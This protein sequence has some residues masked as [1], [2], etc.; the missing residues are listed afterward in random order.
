VK[1]SRWESIAW[2]EE[3]NWCSSST[4][5]SDESSLT[6]SFTGIGEELVERVDYALE[7]VILSIDRVNLDPQ[8][9]EL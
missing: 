5:L 4:Y 8:L 2:I 7:C 9:L 1:F 3:Q 6:V